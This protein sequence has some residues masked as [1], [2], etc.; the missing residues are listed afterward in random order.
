GLAEYC[1]TQDA[2]LVRTMISLLHCCITQ[3]VG[4]G[5]KEDADAQSYMVGNVPVPGKSELSAADLE[6]LFLFALVWSLGATV[7]DAGRAQLSEFL[8]AA[9]RDATFLAT[10]PLAPY[11]EVRGWCAP[12]SNPD[13]RNPY[14]KAGA[15]LVALPPVKASMYDVFYC[16]GDSRW[17]E[18]TAA[19][20]KPIIPATAMYAD[21]LVPTVASVQFDYFVPLLLT[22]KNSV[23]VCGP[24]GTG[25]SVYM[26]RLLLSTLSKAACTSIFVAFSARTSAAATQAMVDVKLDKRRKG[27]YGPP[28]GETCIVFVDDLNLPEP[29]KWG[30]MPP[31]ELLRQLC[32]AGGW[33]DL[34]EN[35][36][37]TIE[38][39]VVAAAMGPPGGGRNFVPSRLLRHFRLLCVTELD[40]RTLKGIFST[41]MSWFMSKTSFPAEVSRLGDVVVNATLELYESAIK[42]LRPTP[43]KSH[44]TFNLRDF[45]RVVEGMLLSSPATVPSGASFARLWLH[46]ATRVFHDRLVSDDDRAWLLGQLKLLT[47]KHFGQDMNALCSQLIVMTDDMERASATPAGGA[48]AGGSSSDASEAPGAP[49]PTSEL[50]VEHLRTLLWLDFGGA[51]KGG[52][53]EISSLPTAMARLDAALT[54]YNGQSKKPMDLVMFLFFMEHVTR[55]ARVL[56]V[57]GGHCLLVG[58]GGSGRRCATRLAAFL[59]ECTV[60]EVELSKSY[61][62]TEWRDD[63]KR[64]LR[65]AGTSA[66]PVLFMFADTQLKWE[67]MLEDINAILNSGEVP[68]LFAAD[69]RAEICEKVTPTARAEGL[70]R[71]ASL[72]ELFAFFVT[73]VRR[74]LH[75]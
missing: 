53:A 11:Y 42:G 40:E 61:G 62:V 46:E 47:R 64:I 28:P 44:Y 20:A 32:D 36:F 68:G 26:K 16:A 13:P 8:Q 59:V 12:G 63:L 49:P 39:T 23:L 2:M 29:E 73:R 48:P 3:A 17:R 57:A 51:A 55:V 5:G 60:M 14:S 43:V 34:V 58:V 22:Q 50:A 15:A 66:Q 7:D 4:A 65:E 71:D 38:D 10:H 69:E 6:G 19:V 67:G 52:Y 1:P 24:T 33:Y 56:R 18:W 72:Q 31:L 54:E 35:E 21:I 45:S 74:N 75:V 37:K 27:V 9:V 30:A 41:V 25:K 70:G